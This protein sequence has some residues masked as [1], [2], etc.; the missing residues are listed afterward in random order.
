MWRAYD[1]GDGQFVP[2]EKLRKKGE[3]RMETQAH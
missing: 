1:I 3:R 2:Y